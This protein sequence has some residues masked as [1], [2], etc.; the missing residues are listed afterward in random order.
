MNI[1]VTGGAGFIGSNLVDSLIEL[2]HDVTI[3]DNLSTGNKENIN[4]RAK[5][6][7]ADIQIFKTDEKFDVIY[8]IASLARIQPSIE[9]PVEF[10]DTNLTGTLEMLML[11]KN[12][13]AKF[14]F[15]S[16]SSIYG[17]QINFPT[18]EETPKHP[19][20]PY[21]AQ[22]QMSEIYCQLFYELYGLE[23]T[24]LRYFNVYG[25]RQILEG[26]Y[27]AIVGIFLNQLE[28]NKPFTIVGDGTQKRDFTYV[29]DVVSA[30]VMAME[31][32]EF[33]TFNVGTGKN[34]SINELADLVSKTHPRI[35]LP[36]RS[37]EYQ[38]TRA[39]NKNIKKL[40]WQ[41][42]ITLEQWIKNIKY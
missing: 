33:N 37:G 25:E 9:N 5:F 21:S 18:S 36:K 29:K 16:S 31:W 34:Y 42:T 35:Y 24:V 38:E 20:S 15:S 30:N 14:I 17:D 26:A 10:H 6:I 1:L 7:L 27:A 3:L 19:G 2:G 11:A 39:D 23:V 12:C 13:G 8:H 41:P 40:G 28:N 22:K 4:P 32:D